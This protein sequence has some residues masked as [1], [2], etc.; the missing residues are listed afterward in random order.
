MS[1]MLIP[2]M[3]FQGQLQIVLHRVFCS[4]QF[5]FGDNIYFPC[6]SI[7]ILLIHVTLKVIVVKV[8]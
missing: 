3:V 6:Q 1:Q 5:F 8:N 2:L 7:K 4:V